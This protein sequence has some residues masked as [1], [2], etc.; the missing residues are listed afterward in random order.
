MLKAKAVR[1]F[2]LD[3]QNG[4]LPGLMQNPESSKMLGEWCFLGEVFA[5]TN[6]S[7]YYSRKR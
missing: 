5:N 2:Q 4:I 1:K 6:S 7:M 3:L